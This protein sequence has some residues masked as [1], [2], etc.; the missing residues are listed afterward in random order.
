MLFITFQN[1]YLFSKHVTALIS[2][3]LSVLVLIVAELKAVKG[4]GSARSVQL[5]TAPQQLEV[6]CR[7]H[8]NN[9]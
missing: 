8:R 3:G 6:V 7:L 1:I 5:I 4:H 9:H 2:E